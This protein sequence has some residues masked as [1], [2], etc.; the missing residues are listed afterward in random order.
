MGLPILYTNDYCML[1]A[2][3]RAKESV[4]SVVYPI[5]HTRQALR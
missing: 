5:L 4:N 1:Q 2:Y 3:L